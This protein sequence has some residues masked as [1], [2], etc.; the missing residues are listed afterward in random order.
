LHVYRLEHSR[1][2]AT[3]AAL[4]P[5]YLKRLPNDPFALAGPL[6]YEP[7]RSKYVLYSVGPDSKD[8]G[9]RPIVDAKAPTSATPYWRHNVDSDSKGDIVAGVNT[10]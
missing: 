7:V 3:L 10:R 6:R 8:D 5:S 4:V 1:H 2:P 9:G